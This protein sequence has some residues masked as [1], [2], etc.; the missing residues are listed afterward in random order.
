M[1]PLKFDKNIIWI[2]LRIQQSAL[3]RCHKGCF[4]GETPAPQQQKFH[5]DVAKSE[6]RRLYSQAT[7]KLNLAEPFSVK[8]PNEV[9]WDVD[10][11]YLNARIQDLKAKWG[12]DLELTVCTWC[13]MPERNIRIT[14]LRANLGRSIG[15]Y[16]EQKVGRVFYEK[17]SSFRVGALGVTVSKKT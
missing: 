17:L 15:F 3:A 16:L 5:A 14:G 4:A 8:S 11:L 2:S 10:L 1:C 6:E 9:F 13:R 12:P 7:N